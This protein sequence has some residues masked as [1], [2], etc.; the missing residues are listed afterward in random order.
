MPHR[1]RTGLVAVAALLA[2]AGPVLAQAPAPRPAAPPARPAAPE[3]VTEANLSRDLLKAMYDAA[4]VP[5]SVD[6]G[7]NLVVT[8]PEVKV[9]VLPGKDSVR[10][11][12]SYDFAPRATR[13][14]RLDLANRI[15]DDY[16]MARASLPEARPGTLAVDYYV[17]LGAGMSRASLVAITRRFGEVVVEAIG[18]VDTDRLIQ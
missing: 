5:A 17:M 13:Q 11:M 15:N 16:I 18:V 12:A 1:F 2:L 14:E 6:G 8:L 3:L 7:G 10:L 4:R 9:F